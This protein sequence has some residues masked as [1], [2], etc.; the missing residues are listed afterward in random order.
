M[1]AR[2]V[3][4]EQSLNYVSGIQEVA[5]ANRFKKHIQVFHEF[6]SADAFTLAAS[7]FTSIDYVDMDIQGGETLICDD[8]RVM[9][10]RT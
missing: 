6:F 7:G 3:F 10:T 2:A 5:R 8:D 9:Q 1:Q 4:W